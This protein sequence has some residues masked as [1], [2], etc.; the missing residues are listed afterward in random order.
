MS[1]VSGASRAFSSV[2]GVVGRLLDGFQELGSASLLDLAGRLMG[3]ASGIVNLFGAAIEGL[4]SGKLA[5]GLL[6]VG[7]MLSG[8]LGSVIAGAGSLFGGALGTLGSLA[9]GGVLQ[10]QLRAAGIAAAW[11]PALSL[12]ALASLN[13][14]R[15]VSGLVSGLGGLASRIKAL[16]L[17]TASKMLKKASNALSSVMELPG[18]VLG[19]LRDAL[20]RSFSRLAGLGLIDGLGAMGFMSKANAARLGQIGLRSILGSGSNGKVLEPAARMMAASALAG[21]LAR[22]PAALGR[23]AL[24]QRVAD[25][26]RNR[27]GDA[28]LLLDASL[29]G[30]SDFLADGCAFQTA[31][32]SAVGCVRAG[33]RTGIDDLLATLECRR[34]SMDR[35]SIEARARARAS[36]ALSLR[37]GALDGLLDG[38]P[39]SCAYTGDRPFGAC[40]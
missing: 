34:S 16:C 10:Q 26:A 28:G 20:S 17:D 11:P 32:Q 13:P 5:G 18:R 30:V 8:A 9:A 38:L 21:L 35:A 3:A 12:S 1:L 2:A 37:L 15:L 27:T 33:V 7:D 39:A 22:E 31:V 40:S 19:A 25:A 24:A 23:L 36:A 4:L 14:G 29:G 6:H